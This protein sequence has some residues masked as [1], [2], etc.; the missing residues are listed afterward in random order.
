MIDFD[1]SAFES[2][3]T[4]AKKT[5]TESV[6]EETLR[7]VGFSAAEVFRDEAKQN[8][9]KNIQTGTLYRSI[10]AK[11]LTEEADG[12]RRQS[13]LVTVRS[14]RYGGEDAFYW[15]FV[16]DGHAKVRENKTVSA[17]T[18]RIVGWKRH[19]ASEAEYWKKK[20]AELEHGTATVPANP[21]MRPAFESKKREA[22][23][24]M[25]RT[26]AEQIDRNLKKS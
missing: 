16:E 13:Y 3:M 24:V 25:T 12:G 14:G 10:I 15:R 21:F 22:V 17:K 26:L 4:A 1:M 5:I 18:G 6:G 11:R 7:T 2:A 20:A 9:L 8:A 23:D 19:R